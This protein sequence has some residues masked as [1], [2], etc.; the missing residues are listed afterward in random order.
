MFVK[1]CIPFVMMAPAME[2]Y[3][4]IV[5]G[6]GYAGTEATLAAARMGARTLRVTQ[7]IATNGQISCIPA[8]GGIGAFPS[9]VPE[10]LSVV[11]R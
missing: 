10:T 1:G 7:S 5:I 3:D 4:V 6:G 8:I 2:R 11:S 9:R